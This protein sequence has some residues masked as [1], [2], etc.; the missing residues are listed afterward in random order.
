[1]KIIM[2]NALAI[3]IVAMVVYATLEARK[4]ITQLDRKLDDL[5]DE[6][7]WVKAELEE[8]IGGPRP[9][10]RPEPVDADVIAEVPTI[11]GALPVARVVRSRPEPVRYYP[12]KTKLPGPGESG[13]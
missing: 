2:M 3:W 1:M 11:V 7:R 6:L 12:P 13:S 9:F 10:N 5:R 4:R 8:L